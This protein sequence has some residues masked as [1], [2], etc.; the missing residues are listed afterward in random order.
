[1][2]L[3][4]Y[5]EEQILNATLR[6]QNMTGVT[7]YVALFTSNP[8]E[9]GEGTEVSGGGYE[10]VQ[11]TF[12]APSNGTCSNSTDIVFPTATSSWGTI[13]HFAIMSAAT[14]GNMWYYGPID[15]AT[16]V[17]ANGTFKFPAGN[18]TFTID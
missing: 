8:G 13:T 12:T 14:G 6:G 9:T 4:N 15:K 7:P 2:S 5:G 17:N 10:R 16:T 1:M 11:A 18:L 3:T